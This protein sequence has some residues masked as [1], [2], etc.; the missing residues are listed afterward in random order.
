ME[1]MLETA[2]ASPSHPQLTLSMRLI[3]AVVDALGL[4]RGKEDRAPKPCGAHED[5]CCLLGH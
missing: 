5:A 3:R 2:H 1:V 4:M